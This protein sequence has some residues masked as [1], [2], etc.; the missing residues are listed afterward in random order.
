MLSVYWKKKAHAVL[1]AINME[2][3]DKSE[4]WP[5]GSKKFA[6]SNQLSMKYFLLINVNMPTF[7]GILTF[8]SRNEKAF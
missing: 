7:V 6:C 4:T 8:M 2:E 1:V 3:E 5:R